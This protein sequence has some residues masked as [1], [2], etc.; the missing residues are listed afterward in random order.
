MAGLALLD[1]NFPMREWDR[2]LPQAEQTLNLLRVARA[3]PKL[4][5]YAY[6]FGHFDWNTTPL[7]PPGIR[8]L[9]H[10]KPT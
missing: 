7:V 10:N 5:V 4:S 9:A 3:K 6:I 1:P 8:V 2:L